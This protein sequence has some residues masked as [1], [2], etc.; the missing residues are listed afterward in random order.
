PAQ[1][2][3]E[4]FRLPVTSFAEEHG[5]FVSSSRLLQWHWQAQPG[6][7]Q[8]RSDLEIMAGLHLRIREAYKKDGGK[9]PDP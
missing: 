7:G 1:I 4:V 3:T 6:P 8:T 5:S 9:F 2:Q